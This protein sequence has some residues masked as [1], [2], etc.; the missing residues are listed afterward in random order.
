MIVIYDLETL[1]DFFLYVD[2]ELNTDKFNIFEISNF[3]NDLNDL[4]KHLKILKGQIGFNNVNFDGQVQQWLIENYKNLKDLEGKL[5]ANDIAQY[6]NYVIQKSN[7]NE[8]LDYREYEFSI[9]QVDLYKVWHFNNKAKMTSLKWLQYMTDWSPIEDMPVD[10]NASISNRADAH[11]IIEY[12]KND[13]LSTKRFY[14][15]TRG[16]T[17]HPLYKG[18][19]RLQLR[20]DVK[21]EF[22]IDCTNYD[23]VKIGDSINKINYLNA[24]GLTAKD[25]KLKRA[26]VKPFT[27]EDCFPSY[28]KF[29]TNELNTFID[30]IRRITV[31]TESKQEFHFKF[32]QTNYVLA[33]GGLHS[34]DKPRLVK[35]TIDQILRDADVGGMYPNAIRKRKLYPEHLGPLWLGMVDKLIDDRGEAKKKYEQTK[36]GKYKSIVE[37]Y[38]LAANGGLFGKLQE[39]TSWQYSPKTCFDITIGSQIDLLMLIER[40]ELGGIRVISAN[41]DGVV[42]LFNKNQDELYKKICTE[43]EELVGNHT[44]GKLEYSDYALLAQRSV[45]HY[46]AIKA[47]GKAKHKGSFSVNHELHKN[48]SYR[49]TALALD[50]FYR[51]GLNPRTFILAHENIFDFCAGMRTKGEWY[52]EARSMVNGSLKTERLQKTNRYFISN[53]GVKLIKCHPDG[54]Q[55]Q[56]DAGKWQSTIYNTHVQKDMKDY[57]INY[58]F[59]VKQVYEILG[60]IDPSITNEHYT[61]LDLF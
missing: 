48:K 15:I 16:K 22:G 49:I 21:A 53:K 61:Q 3:Q 40:F 35:P 25:L 19:D 46:I 18:I 2:V 11:K 55:I 56:E 29:E 31:L 58:D 6:A 34:E 24:T 37:T 23:D 26:V 45:N 44:Q 8:W 59:Y 28:V 9:R 36:E 10:H 14:E 54:R 51:Q 17:E 41:T 42:C 38:K 52:L 7:S 33:K 1:K 32:G 13:C 30:S 4:V 39:K 5:V 20:K 60:E 43:W 50:A 47:D 12:C 27:F 57:D